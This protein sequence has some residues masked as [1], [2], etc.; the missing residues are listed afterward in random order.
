ML[1]NLLKYM[2]L[3][4]KKKIYIYIKYMGTYLKWIRERER[5]VYKNPDKD[6]LLKIGDFSWKERNNG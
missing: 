2:Y 5:L 3:C 1:S 6:Y 4:Q